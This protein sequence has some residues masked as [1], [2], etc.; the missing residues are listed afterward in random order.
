MKPSCLHLLIVCD[1]GFISLCVFEGNALADV[2]LFACSVQ[3]EQQ[4]GCPHQHNGPPSS[5]TYDHCSFSTPDKVHTAIS[6]S[7]VKVGLF[8]EPLHLP[9]ISV[10]PLTLLQKRFAI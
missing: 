2:I 5:M 7:V 6:A 8:S 9:I 3:T 1:L 10:A 4:H